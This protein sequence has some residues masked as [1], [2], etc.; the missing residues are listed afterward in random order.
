MAQI[1]KRGPSY[2]VRITWRDVDGKQHKKSKSGFKTKA[3]ARKAAAEMEMNKY[4]GQ[5]VVGDPTFAG[6]FEDWYQTYKANKVSH[7]TSK[8]YQQAINLVRREI[9]YDEVIQ[10]D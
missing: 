2:M 5:A 3:E 10:G 9:W 7:S 6:Y 4:A 1:I 8:A